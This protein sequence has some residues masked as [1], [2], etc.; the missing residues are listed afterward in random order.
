[1][2]Y[3]IA[4]KKE[5]G[6]HFIHTKLKNKT[7][8]AK[9]SPMKNFCFVLLFLFSKSLSAQTY[10]FTKQFTPEE[11]R[12][13][14]G[15]NTEVFKLNSNFSANISDS[16]TE[17]TIA[18]MKDQIHYDKKYLEQKQAE[19]KKDSLNPYSLNDVAMYYETN[20]DL[21][22]A[23]K[24]FQKA[25]KNLPNLL[26]VKKDSA[27]FYSLRGLIKVHLQEK[28]PMLDLEKALRINPLDSIANTFY[29]MFLM[30]SG[31]IDDARQFA[32]KKLD[33]N[34]LP[35]YY[36]V[37]LYMTYLGDIQG[38][39]SDENKRKDNSQKEYDHLIDFSLLDKYAAKYKTNTQVQNTRKIIEV[40][41]LFFKM[42]TFKL[43][44]DK[45]AFVLKFS[46]K[47]KNKTAEM[48]G[49]FTEAIQKKT[50]NP[51][52]GNKYL[53]LLYYMQS[54]PDKV[55]ESAKKS[56][57]ALPLAKQSAN[58]NTNDAYDFV[59]NVYNAKKDY[60]AYQK[61]LQEK[62]EKGYNDGSLA[63]E[64]LD[65]AVLYLY[66]NNIDKADEWC[67]KSKSLNAEDFQCLC[68]LS[69]IYYLNDNLALS[70]YYGDSAA[71]YITGDIDKAYLSL[72]FSI[73][74]ILNGSEGTAK[75]ANDGIVQAKKDLDNDCPVC[76]DLLIKYIK[77]TP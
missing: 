29:P 61:A 46:E 34:E 76:D 13:F 62:M 16:D 9:K 23:K 22:S 44:Q 50:M 38:L 17:M 12:D 75:G 32:M 14:I 5:T 39:F 31:R 41:M 24:Y 2:Y 64:Y 69:H 43:N 60:L 52:T 7:T 77:V 56:I 63:K 57:A 66:Q 48:I 35:K 33:A 36:Y 25:Y 21:V 10:E 26:N 11:K 19:L 54:K 59:L 73:Y 70:Q 45:T 47:E 27:Q 28:E 42:A 72:Q 67:K 65:M 71:R 15:L 18:A 3:F 40:S 53:A 6:F 30:N 58:F 49:L 20:N 51:Y 8:L 4:Q 37:L 74:L 68:L 1:M 55:L